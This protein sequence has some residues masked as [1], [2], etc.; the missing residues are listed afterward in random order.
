MP[1]R[2]SWCSP[3]VAMR[4]MEIAGTARINTLN[5]GG[6]APVRLVYSRTKNRSEGGTR[7]TDESF[8]RYIT[9]CADGSSRTAPIAS[10]KA[11]SPSNRISEMR[12]GAEGS[13]RRS[14]ASTTNQPDSTADRKNGSEAGFN[15]TGSLDREM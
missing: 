1:V 12:G 4:L 5:R 10:H 11:Q 13:L 8:K 9:A 14:Q 6:A 2:N 7:A 3:D 15:C